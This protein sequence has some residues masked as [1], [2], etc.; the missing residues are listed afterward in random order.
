HS[1]DREVLGRL[2]IESGETILWGEIL[3]RIRRSVAPED[4]DSICGS[5]PWLPMGHCKAGLRRLRATL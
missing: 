1:Q 3:E 5:C 4:L 2:G